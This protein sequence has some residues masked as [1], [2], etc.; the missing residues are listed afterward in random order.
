MMAVVD[1]GFMAAE[2]SPV[3]SRH[4]LAL[5]EHLRRAIEALGYGPP[6]PIQERAIPI[7]IAGRDVIAEAQTGSGKTAAFV[8]PIVKSIY[9]SA[10]SRATRVLTLAPTRELALQVVQSFRE[11]S[12]YAPWQLT[13]LAVIGGAP[14]ED[15]IAALDAGVQVV[16]AT[17]GRLLDLMERQALDLSQVRTLVLDEADR[18]LDAGFTEAVAE[19]L[20]ALPAERQTLLFS[21]TLPQSVLSVSERLLRDPVTVRIDETPTPV[22]GIEQRAYEVNRDKRR[23]L[24]QHLVRAESWRQ[25][26]VFVATRKASENLAHKLRA[27]G[28]HAAAL[29]GDLDQPTRVRALRRFKA[30]GLPLLIATDLA[31]RGID[32]PRLDA[33]VNYDLPRST[34]DYV[35]RIGRTG[36][37]GATGVAVSFI[38]HE[39]AEH[40]ELIEKR[41]QL[42]ITR[43]QVPGFELTGEAPRRSAGGAPVKGRRKSKK[44]RLREKAAREEAGDDQTG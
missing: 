32:I 17:P 4:P 28:F 38:N 1:R 14:I 25:T 16:V 44:D 9:E 2:S 11:L 8:L 3:T 41:H 29:H 37:A 35:H 36:R 20:E 24:L 10:P 18:L 15:Q 31:A 43:L 42:E 30:G 33:V 39:N 27:A 22:A 26:L 40:F 19:L 7:I 13:V 5:P 34:R 12:D 23:P 21:A 6:T